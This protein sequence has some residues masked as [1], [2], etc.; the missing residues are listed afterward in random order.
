MSEA[1]LFPN[2]V[3]EALRPKTVLV[4]GDFM[5]DLY[6]VGH[7]K[8]LSP[9][10]PVPVLC[11]THEHMR[12]G[13]AG[14]AVLNLLSLGMHVKVMGRVGDDVSGEQLIEQLQ[15]EGVDTTHL[16]VDSSYMTPR[17]NRI[18]ADHYQLVRVDY[19]RP[20]PL[21]PALEQRMIDC[22]PHLLQSCDIIAISDYAKGFLTPHLLQAVMQTSHVPVVVDPKGLDFKRYRGATVIKPNLAEAIAA[23]GLGMEASLDDIAQKILREIEVSTL[24]ITRSQDGISIFEPGKPRTDYPAFVHQVR[25]VT[26]AGDTVLAVITATLANGWGLPESAQLANRAA[27]IAIE[28]VGCARVSLADL[29]L[30][31]ASV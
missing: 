19:E 4:I 9:E 8:R 11:V 17:K 2:T 21:E 6:T 27:A 26:G 3:C 23:A 13:G 22:L 16:I 30:T 25:D 12:A 5:L 10:A 29:E 7:A 28:R 20:A 15:K 24:V 18:M 1:M 14:N 31:L